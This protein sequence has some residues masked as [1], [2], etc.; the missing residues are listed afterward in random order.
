MNA[1]LLEIDLHARVIPLVVAAVLAATAGCTEQADQDLNPDA[2]PTAAP[3]Q[4]YEKLSDAS[5][6]RESPYIAPVKTG[7]RITVSELDFWP[8]WG[9][10]DVYRDA[11]Q[12]PIG[13]QVWAPSELHEADGSVRLGAVGRVGTEI[14]RCEW[15]DAVLV[16]Q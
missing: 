4:V 14:A 11:D 10:G 7:T 12:Q 3:C 16:L 5:W 2:V 8:L 1:L 13:T 6:R 9:K 15:L